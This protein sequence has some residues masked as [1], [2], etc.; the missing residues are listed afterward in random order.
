[1]LDEL[2]QRLETL[3]DE[4]REKLN[5]SPKSA[6]ALASEIRIDTLQEV[7]ELIEELEE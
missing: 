4:A 5:N 3:I 2:K 6:R 1:M 7:M